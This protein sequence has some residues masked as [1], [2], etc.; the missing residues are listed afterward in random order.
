MNFSRL[1]LCLASINLTGFLIAAETDW[2]IEKLEGRGSMTLIEWDKYVFF[3]EHMVDEGPGQPGRPVKT[4]IYLGSAGKR[5]LVQT[6]EISS[7][8]QIP[9]LLSV[10]KS[11]PS[12]QFSWVSLSTDQF[13]INEPDQAQGL[14]RSGEEPFSKLKVT[15]LSKLKTQDTAEDIFPEGLGLGFP[16][17]LDLSVKMHVLDPQRIILSIEYR[18]NNKNK[19]AYRFTSDGGETWNTTSFSFNLA[20][21]YTLVKADHLQRRLCASVPKEIAPNKT[22]PLLTC[23]DK[24]TFP[25]FSNVALPSDLDAVSY[26]DGDTLFGFRKNDFLRS[27]DFGRTWETVHKLA[28]E[29]KVTYTQPFGNRAVFFG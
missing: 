14:L 27:N 11:S 24:K 2:K 18:Q 5:K 19:I 20:H 17:A 4:E 12:A 3:K 7:L 26:A 8:F 22:Q 21:F 16:G 28:A 25:K 13:P 10:S 1:F 15:N 9:G 29:V 6:I 23:T